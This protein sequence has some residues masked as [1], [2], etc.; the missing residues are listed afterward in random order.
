MGPSYD[1]RIRRLVGDGQLE[2]VKALAEVVLPTA[3][4][5]YG[6][7]T[8]VLWTLDET[9]VW[10]AA[11]EELSGDHRLLLLLEAPL[12][13]RATPDGRSVMW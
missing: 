8:G 9:G 6:G 5:T 3:P 13:L 2:E 11:G 1:E 4:G 7:Q 10:R 12:S